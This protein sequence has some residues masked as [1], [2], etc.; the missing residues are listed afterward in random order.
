M[1]QSTIL[2]SMEQLADSG[3]VPT[4]AALASVPAGP[5]SVARPPAVA[6]QQVANN[7]AHHGQPFQGKV[8]IFHHPAK[9]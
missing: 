1:L 4:T 2:P 9:L 6:A 5:A 7:M 3:A 8:A